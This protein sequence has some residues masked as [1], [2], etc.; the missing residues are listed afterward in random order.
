[1]K[2]LRALTLAEALIQF[3]SWLNKKAL[4][5]L[6]AHNVKTFDA[7]HLIKALSLRNNMKEFSHMVIEFSFG[8]C[9]QI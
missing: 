2:P 1:M 8:S 6:L 5:I 7:K 4:C 9:F 3:L